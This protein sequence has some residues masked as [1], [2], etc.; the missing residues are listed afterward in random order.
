MSV[1]LTGARSPLRARQLSLD[2][3]TASADENARLK[4]EGTLDV[5][6]GTPHHV[7]LAPYGITFWELLA[8]DR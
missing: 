5:E 2:A 4:P 1:E 6:Q 3:T 7:R 8:R